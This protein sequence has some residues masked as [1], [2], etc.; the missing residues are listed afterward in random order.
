MTPLEHA[1]ERTVLICATRS[2]VFRFFTDSARFADWWGAGSS[3]DARPGGAVLIRY[4]NGVVASGAVLE[5][6]ADERIVFTYGYEAP[7]K[8]IAPGGSRVIITL[9]DH[10][11]GTLLELRH[12][13]A[14]AATRDHHVPGWRHQL[15]LFAVAAAR[16]QHRD[17][18]GAIDRYLALW[19]EPDPAARRAALAALVTDEV[20]FRDAFGC[21]RGRDELDLHIAAAQMHMPDMRLGREGDARQCQGMAIADWAAV[22]SDGAPRAHG[23]NVF[24]LAPD[25]RIARVVGFWRAAG[26]GS[27][28]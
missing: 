16:E 11:A 6:V 1:L 18:A 5:V 25:G 15:A 17:V 8:P 12:E 2:T 19:S 20:I 27:A 10:E 3:I 24:E 14:D 26:Q 13:M 9:R 4:P 7:D 22:A 23:T 28:A 21:T